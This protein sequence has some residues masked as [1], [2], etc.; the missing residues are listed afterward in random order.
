MPN[1]NQLAFAAASAL[2]AI[3]VFALLGPVLRR[4]DTTYNYPS[5]SSLNNGGNGTKAYFAALAR[6][7][8]APSRNFKSLRKLTGARAAIFYAG[9]EL[10]SFRYS[11]DQELKQFEQLAERGARVVIALDPEAVVEIPQQKRTHPPPSLGARPPEDNL[12]KR[13]GIETAYVNRTVSHENREFLAGLGVLPVTWRFSSWSGTWRPSHLRNG[14]PLFLERAFG[15]GS[16]VVIANSKLFTNRE[17]LI[18]PDSDVLASAPGGYRSVIFDENHLGLADTGTVVGLAVA[19]DLEWMLLGFL[20]LAI[21]Y[22]WRSS[23]SFVPRLSAPVEASVSGRDAHLALSHLLMQ[24]IPSGS[25]LR[26][27]AEEWNR[28]AALQ[29]RA[30]SRPLSEND[31]ERLGQLRPADVAAE[32]RA[33]AA[34]LNSH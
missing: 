24:S 21:L 1:R 32:Y 12:K 30:T 11:D 8:L 27:A 3:F 17:L 31:L 26:V 18:H 5:Y 7:G 15:Q 10:W 13:W 4:T 16:I 20:V 33:L 34:Q 6:L 22:V 28:S 2:A 23:V 19:H 14:S 25:V 29:A 9:S